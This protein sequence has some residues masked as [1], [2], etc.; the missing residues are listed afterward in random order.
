MS[1]LATEI[2]LAYPSVL[3]KLLGLTRCVDAAEDALHD[4]IERALET[5][6][7][8]GRPDSA[9]AWLLTVASNR[10]RDGL[11]RRARETRH[12]PTLSALAQLSPIAGGAIRLPL[13]LRGWDDD[14]LRLLFTCCHPDLSTGEQAAL[15]L[16]TVLGLSTEEVAAA[17]LAQPR[18][19]EQRLTRA[20]KRLRE[21][22]A[23]YEVPR[24]DAA[25]PRLEAV[26]RVVYLLFN[27]GYWSSSS[28][29]SPLRAE[30]CALALG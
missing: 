23:Q 28:E 10:F 17:F 11:R 2:R 6:P 14:L 20:R 12:A 16:S 24:P 18:T 29:G 4:A 13:S 27:E 26:L 15:T 21:R 3:A 25:R 30:L 1:D 22:G 9:E 7:R 5:W 8:D 19:M